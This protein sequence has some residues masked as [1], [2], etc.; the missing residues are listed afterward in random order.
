MQLG[1]HHQES[2]QYDNSL[3]MFE[4]PNEIKARRYS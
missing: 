3:K 2:I 4:G 1:R